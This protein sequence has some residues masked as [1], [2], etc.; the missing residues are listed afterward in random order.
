MLFVM[1]VQAEAKFAPTFYF[2]EDMTPFYISA[3]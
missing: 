2:Q 1:A 3:I